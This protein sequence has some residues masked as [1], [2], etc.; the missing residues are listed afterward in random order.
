MKENSKNSQTSDSQRFKAPT[1]QAK[2][3]FAIKEQKSE[4]SIP[5]MGE[6]GEGTSNLVNSIENVS[7]LKFL[8]FG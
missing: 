3:P 8:N 7:K 6:K 1:T 2:L 4:A 5:A